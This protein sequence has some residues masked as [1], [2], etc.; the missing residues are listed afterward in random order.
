LLKNILFDLGFNSAE[1][2]IFLVLYERG[3]LTA[4][5]AAKYA[6]INRT[7][8]YMIL[9]KLMKKGLVRQDL[10]S[11]VARFA[12]E[13]PETLVHY[14]EGRQKHFESLKDTIEK[15]LPELES[16]NP[17]SNLPKI[18]LFEGLEGAKNCFFQLL[19]I[20]EQEKE[21]VLRGYLMPASID[22]DADLYNFVH[23]HYIKERVKKGI[24]VKN[25]TA[26][27]EAGFKLLEADKESL[28]KTLLVPESKFSFNSSEINIIGSY[29]HFLSYGKNRLVSV[30]IYDE[31]FAA[32]QRALWDVAWEQA[33]NYHKE[34]VKNLSNKS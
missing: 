16:L 9:Q 12:A 29:F 27:T 33:N 17:V 24:I 14:V 3:P 1:I 34:L 26:A 5:K 31:D 25:I 21:K 6:D 32:T 11:K 8:S 19:K 4:S 20:A 30:I 7:A 15:I 13:R 23:K 18:Q 28:R 2:E 22:V 10:S